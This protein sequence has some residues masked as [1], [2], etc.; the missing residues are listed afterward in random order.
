MKSSKKLFKRSILLFLP[1]FEA[2]IH[3]R[4]AVALCVN[5]KDEKK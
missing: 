3:G 2:I 1:G 5:Q 4:D